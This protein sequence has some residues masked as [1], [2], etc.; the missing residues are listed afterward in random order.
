[1]MGFPPLS[2]T[3]EKAVGRLRDFMQKWAVSAEELQ[4]IKGGGSRADRASGFMSYFAT[5]YAGKLRMW[6][7]AHRATILG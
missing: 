4:R 1:M 5:H 2:Q 6:A 3:E 7:M